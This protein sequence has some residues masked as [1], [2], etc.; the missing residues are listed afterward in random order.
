MELRQES[1]LDAA[2]SERIY[3]LMDCIYADNAFARQHLSLDLKNIVKMSQDIISDALNCIMNAKRAGKGHVIIKRKS[4]L[5]NEVL[6]I[7]RKDKY[8]LF[9][10]LDDGIKVEF[11]LNKCA[12]IKPRFQVKVEEIEKYIKRF[13]PARNFGILIL[14]TDNGLISHEEAIK[15][16]IGGSLIA[17]FY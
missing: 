11:E 14:S 1:A 17:Y 4:K 6:K 5:L 7:A 3:A 8:L 13:L 10:I 12:A 15:K 2:E 16:N 9:D